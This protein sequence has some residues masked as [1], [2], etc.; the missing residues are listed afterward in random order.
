MSGEFKG[1]PG[2]WKCLREEVNKHYIR[3]SGTKVGERFAVAN[4]LIPLYDD[5]YEREAKET[6]ANAQLIAAAPEMLDLL[7]LLLDAQLLPEFHLN[8]A[9]KV[10][11]KALGENQ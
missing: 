2:P 10:V 11:A 8:A 6:R 7:V 3:I 9:N 1:T 5:V 4:V